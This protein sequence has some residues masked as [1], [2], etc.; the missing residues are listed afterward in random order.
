MFANILH[1]STINIS[2]P[3]AQVD[4]VDSLVKQYGFANRSE[5]IRSILRMLRQKPHVMSEASTFPFEPPSTRSR[6]AILTSMKQAG[7]YSPEL[8][9][10]L[11]K[12]L[13][14]SSFFT[15]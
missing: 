7:K 2:L 15:A 8:L 13:E 12:G 3:S 9:K 5:F 11:K 6:S 10:S 14:E 1:M 4:F